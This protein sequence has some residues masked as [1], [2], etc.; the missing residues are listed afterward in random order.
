MK[1]FEGHLQLNAN[2]RVAILVARFN[3]FVVNSLLEGAIDSLNR[4]GLPKDNIDVIYAPGA[5]ELPLAAK[6]AAMQQRYDGIVALG[7]VIRGGTAHFEYVAGSCIQGLS[8]VG[9]DH[10]LPIGLGVLT[11][12]SIEQAIERSGTKAGNKGEEAALAMIEM[13]NLR[14]SMNSQ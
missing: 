8:K 1:T 13:V 9:L 4:H 11:V 7:V 14:A 6:E 12:E 2:H 10:A 3:H 5:Y